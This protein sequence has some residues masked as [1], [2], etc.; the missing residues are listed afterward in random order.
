MPNL[1]PPTAAGEP[2]LSSL[3][4]AGD[5]RHPALYRDLA[6]RLGRQAPSAAS[7]T[8]VHWQAEALRVQ[9]LFRHR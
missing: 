5:T 4:A 7:E 2:L 1:A 9:R 6:A 8:R 3:L